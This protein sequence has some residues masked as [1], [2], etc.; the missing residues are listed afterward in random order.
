MLRTVKVKNFSNKK[1][2]ND[3]SHNHFNEELQEKGESELLSV[4]KSISS[5]SS[6]LPAVTHLDGTARVQTIGN[7]DESYIYE[8][9][10]DFY[11]LTGCAVLINTSFNVRGEPIVDSPEDAL[12]CFLSTEL[13]LLCI[14]GIIIKIGRAHV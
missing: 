4:R 11:A 8:L 1:I 7:S 13:D 2:Q 14:E 5:I 3:L 6:P 12:N 9:L 10:Q